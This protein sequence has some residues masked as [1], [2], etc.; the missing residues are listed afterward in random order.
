[1]QP[2]EAGASYRFRAQGRDGA[3]AESVV[4]IPRDYDL[5]VWVSQRSNAINVHAEGLKQAPF[6]FWNTSYYD[7]CYTSRFFRKIQ[8]IAPGGDSVARMIGRP[9]YSRELP[10]CDSRWQFG[11]GLPFTRPLR[12]GE[13][14]N[15]TLDPYDPGK[16]YGTA[17]VL[18]DRPFNGQ[19]P[20]M[21]RLDLSLER[22]FELPIGK[23]QLRAGAINA[24]DPRNMFYYD[25][26]SG[27]RVDQLPLAPYASVV[28][29][30]N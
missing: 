12:F 30:S 18:L 20:M 27:C 26:Y 9:E 4:Q 10:V 28:L 7:G 6:A 19:L 24:Y 1:M 5:E 15:Y 17:R 16:S 25:L 8:R 21:H 23:L 3:V 29:R 14:F 2:I 13:A 11:S 22:S